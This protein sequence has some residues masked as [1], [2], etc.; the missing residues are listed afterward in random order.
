[1]GIEFQYASD[2]E[3]RDME[4]VVEGLIF[5]QLGEHLGQK[6]LGRR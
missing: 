2:G 4:R 3:R 1:M 5:A 6:L